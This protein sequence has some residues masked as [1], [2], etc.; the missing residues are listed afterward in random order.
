MSGGYNVL[1]RHGRG[2]GEEGEED[3][4]IQFTTIRLNGGDMEEGES[5]SEGEG[6]GGAREDRKSL[7]KEEEE[8]EIDENG[9]ARDYE[10][11]LKHVGFGLFH[12][13]LLA[14]N[15]VALLS[16]AVEVH[17]YRQIDFHHQA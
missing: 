12:V 13:I 5:G 16:D 14:V 3:G 11:A 15:G 4:Q 1:Y 6:L 17:V 10:V 7:I 9:V 8:D 2:K